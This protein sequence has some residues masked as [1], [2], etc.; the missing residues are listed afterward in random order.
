MSNKQSVSLI[1]WGKN[2]DNAQNEVVDLMIDRF[3]QSAQLTQYSDG[4]YFFLRA[5][6]RHVPTDVDIADCGREFQ[7]LATSL[8]GCSQIEVVPKKLSI[9]L[10]CSSMMHVAESVLS[11]V[12]SGRLSHLDVAF[13][14]SDDLRCEKLAN[15]YGVPF[16]SLPNP[17]QGESLNKRQRELLTRYQ[18]DI[19]GLA[20]YDRLIGAQL[21]GEISSRILSVENAFIPKLRSELAV[22]KAYELGV[23]ASSATAKLA[24]NGNG[25]VILIQAFS[26]L[27]AFPSFDQALE[28]Q[29]HLE[30]K[31][32]LTAL[33]KLVEHK[34]LVYNAR[35]IVFD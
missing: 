11:N 34:V 20:R 17:M 9:G 33:Q 21:A 12:Y 6:W 24:L 5:A 4:D 10:F 32:F 7:V 23:K 27:P 14:A 28:V 25:G 15:R 2:S 30:Q 13:L 22:E 29:H 16:F 19:V 18:P 8:G 31:V 26:E 3:G 35:S 1:F